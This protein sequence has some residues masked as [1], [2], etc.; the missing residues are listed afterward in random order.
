MLIS[1]FLSYYLPYTS[2]TLKSVEIEI[3]AVSGI[4]V[5]SYLS[6][7][8]CELFSLLSLSVFLISLWSV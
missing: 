1:Y 5:L 3:V 2:C 7:L 8:L 6:P 4:C